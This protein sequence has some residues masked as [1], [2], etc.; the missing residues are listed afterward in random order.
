MVDLVDLNSNVYKTKPSEFFHSID[1]AYVLG[2]PVGRSKVSDEKFDRALM[3]L[4]GLGFINITELRDNISDLLSTTAEVQLQ[5]DSSQYFVSGPN[6]EHPL[7]VSCKH[8]QALKDIVNNNYCNAIICEDDVLFNEKFNGLINQ[9]WDALPKDFDIV[10]VGFGHPIRE[11][12]DEKNKISPFIW[13]GAF[14]CS[15]CMVISQDGAK[16]ILANLPMHDQVDYFY[17]RLAAAEIIKC[18]GF[19]Y[20]EQKLEGKADYAP[21]GLAYQVNLGK[22]NDYHYPRGYDLNAS[23]FV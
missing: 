2:A 23:F 22:E 6:R 12:W 13:Q 20:Y 14:W 11:F 19:N 21:C 9:Y 1:H 18:Y 15:H 3:Q 5:Y 8:I 17:G 7:N 4:K 10:Y 16:K